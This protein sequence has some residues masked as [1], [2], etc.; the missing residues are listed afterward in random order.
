MLPL[1]STLAFLGAFST[2]HADLPPEPIPY[3]ERHRPSFFLLGKP[4]TKVQFSFKVQVLRNFPLIF[5]YSQL[6]LWDLF[7]TSLP[8][9]DINFNPEVYYR[10]PYAID[11]GIDHES[12]GKAG[13]D[14]RAWNHASVR[15]SGSAIATEGKIGWSVKLSLPYGMDDE[16]SRRL[17]ERRGLWEIQLNAVNLFKN[18]FEVN[19]L[20]FRI[21]GG[22]NTRVNPIHGGQELTYREKSTERALLVPLYFQVF[23]GYGESLLDADLERWGLRAGVGF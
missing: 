7:E 8:F 2:A 18:I 15:Y 21:Y 10:L 12:N 11:L 19:E 13:L 16:A 5:G 20:I 4:I 17:P 14:S 1:I 9:R 22:G 6:M 23:H 3:F